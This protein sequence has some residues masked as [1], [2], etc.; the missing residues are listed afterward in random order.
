MRRWLRR[1]ARRPPPFRVEFDFAAGGA[2]EARETIDI[3]GPATIVGRSGQAAA[4][5]GRLLRQ[6]KHE[7]VQPR[8]GGGAL[9]DH[10]GFEQTDRLAIVGE[11]HLSCFLSAFMA[12]TDISERQ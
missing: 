1:S 5:G 4:K 6:L 8:A 7:I 2:L 10:Q 12:A 3:N 11:R 9:R